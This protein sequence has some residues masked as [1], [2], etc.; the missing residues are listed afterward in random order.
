MSEHDDS[1]GRSTFLEALEEAYRAQTRMDVA[2]QLDAEGQDANVLQEHIRFQ[3]VVIGLFKRM[4]PY[5]VNELER[6]WEE[7]LVYKDDDGVI[8]GLKELH[9]YEGAI[10]E[11]TGFSGDQQYREAEAV[12]MPPNALRN[13]LDHMSNALYELGMLH[14][15]VAL[16]QGSN[17]SVRPD[18][19]R[20][21]TPGARPPEA[22]NE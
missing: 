19:D 18:D 3:Q 15:S 22:E 5:L 4:R 20:P 13:A 16:R 7:A 17:K 14:D 1:D 2:R 8:R 10:N 9:H 21:T 11:R 12:T 6:Y